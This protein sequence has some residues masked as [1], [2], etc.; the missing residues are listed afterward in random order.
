MAG[1]KTIKRMF[2]TGKEGALAG[3]LIGLASAVAIKLSGGT[4]SF[5]IIDVQSRA[6]DAVSI[7]SPPELAAL[8]YFVTAMAWILVGVA[9]GLFIDLR[10][11]LNFTKK[12]RTTLWVVF[13][14]LLAFVLLG[15]DNLGRAGIDATES[16][17]SLATLGKMGWPFATVIAIVIGQVIGFFNGIFAP[18]P[19]FPIWIF[20]VAGFGIL[21][22]LRRGG[23]RQE[24]PLI[25]RQ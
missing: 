20:F 8:A 18:Q 10:F 5:A 19:Q 2:Q 12:T 14:V 11:G 16:R 7:L 4:F 3:G 9:I 23:G 15:G 21:L 17:S 6:A 24:Q 25:L 13:L 1:F 22:F